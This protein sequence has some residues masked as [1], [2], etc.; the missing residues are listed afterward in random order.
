MTLREEDVY[1]HLK[2]RPEK[3]KQIEELHICESRED[4]SSIC[5]GKLL[6]LTNVRYDLIVRQHTCLVCEFIM[7]G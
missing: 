1:I 3:K 2:Y 7:K 5:L 4:K 6:S